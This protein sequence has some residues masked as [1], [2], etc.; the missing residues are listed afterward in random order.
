MTGCTC[1]ELYRKQKVRAG[2]GAFTAD[3]MLR[4]TIVK[5]SSME[6][7]F[8]ECSNV[9]SFGLVVECKD[10]AND[11][12]LL[13]EITVFWYLSGIKTGKYM[14]QFLRILATHS[15]EIKLHPTLTFLFLNLSR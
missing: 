6:L 1:A 13:A 11:D 5:T 14:A 2:V 3:L 7:D 10:R 8:E 9:H 4:Q 15:T 12:S